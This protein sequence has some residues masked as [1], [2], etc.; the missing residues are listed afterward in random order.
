MGL[1][2]DKSPYGKTTSKLKKDPNYAWAFT[3]PRTAAEQAQYCVTQGWVMGGIDV[4]NW[5]NVEAGDLLFWDR[6]GQ[7]NGRYMSISHVAMVY[8]FDEEGDALS[9][10]VTNKT[11]CIVIKKIKQNT[12]DKLLFV[13]RI[14]KE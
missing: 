1:S 8:G 3:F 12:D 4:T 7:E 11:P 10:E 6:D 2:Y 5:S 14:R 13:A 9:I